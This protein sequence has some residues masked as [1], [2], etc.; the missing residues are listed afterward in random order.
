MMRLI[1]VSG[2]ATQAT[3]LRAITEALGADE[4]SLLSWQELLG[5]SAAEPE[6]SGIAMLS[7]GAVCLGWSLGG[8]LL[9][10][11]ILKEQLKPAALVLLG[12]AACFRRSAKNPHGV[13]RQ[14]LKKM[15]LAMQSNPK[16]VLK[17]FVEACAAPETLTWNERDELIEAAL[18]QGLAALTRGL[19]YLASFDV[20]SSLRELQ[21]PV[22]VIHGREDQIINPE[23]TEALMLELPKASR[24]LLPGAGHRLVHSHAMHCAQAIKVF[25]EHHGL[26]SSA[27]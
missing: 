2:W 27:V 16:A 19:D 10:E 13:D 15:H 11:G 22:L 6:Y 7:R 12:S 5:E 20:L 8:M 18:R 24:V 3:E 23:T 1:A 25:V 21:L 4:Q 26:C 9:L 14:V 17:D